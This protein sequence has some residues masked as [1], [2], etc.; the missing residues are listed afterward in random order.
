MD[1]KKYIKCNIPL[2]SSLSLPAPHAESKTGKKCLVKISKLNDVTK[3][4]NSIQASYICRL[5]DRYAHQSVPRGAEYPDDATLHVFISRLL[6]TQPEHGGDPSPVFYVNRKEARKRECRGERRE[7]P[8]NLYISITHTPLIL[9]APL[10]L[11]LYLSVSILF[12]IHPSTNLT[13]T[14]P[15]PSP[16]LHPLSC[17]HPTPSPLT[18]QPSTSYTPFSISF[19]IVPYCFF[20]CLVFFH[21]F[22]SN[23]RKLLQLLSHS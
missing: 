3:N 5:T 22:S 18:L 21:I 6:V 7:A 1:N 10:A 15:F 14:Y 12:L 19:S 8:V 13:F 20:H 9:H 2:F 11:I 23:R 17:F 16:V 4:I